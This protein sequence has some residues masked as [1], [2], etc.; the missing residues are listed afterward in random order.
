MK[1]FVAGAVLVS[2]FVF[3]VF[4]DGIKVVDSLMND[5]AQVES[6]FVP[7]N[8]TP[9]GPVPLPLL[10]RVDIDTGGD[11]SRIHPTADPV[12]FDTSR[13]LDRETWKVIVLNQY[14]GRPGDTYKWDSNLLGYMAG[15]KSQLTGV[16]LPTEL[17]FVRLN[18]PYRENGWTLP[19]MYRKC[20]PDGRGCFDE[21]L[22]FAQSSL[23]YS[24]ER[25][26]LSTL[27]DRCDLAE[28]TPAMAV[29]IVDPQGQ[30][31]HAYTSCLIQ[32]SA[33]HI[34]K[35]F[36]HHTEAKINT[37]SQELAAIPPHPSYSLETS[38][39]DD[40]KL[41]GRNLIRQAVQAASKAT[42]KAKETYDSAVEE[43]K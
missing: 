9:K 12:E 35:N 7:D 23:D 8:W 33:K 40:L 28:Y 16:G 2:L 26:Y 25:D 18:R 36:A 4:F 37:E 38:V 6:K 20:G 13:A 34:L 19:D 17:W 15:L 29:V 39:R 22:V 31:R 32:I 27:D 43:W 42:E 14:K 10:G 30:M 1:I 41:Q 3:A 21:Y 24:L 5:Q 11:L